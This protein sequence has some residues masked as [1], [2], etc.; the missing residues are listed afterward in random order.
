MNDL[1]QLSTLAIYAAMACYAI[2]LVGFSVDLSGLTD[3]GPSGRRRRA[4]GIAMATTNAGIA[5]HVAGVVLRGLAAGRVPWANMYEFTLVFS[6]VA[7]L[8]FVVMQRRRDVR[9][10]G[11]FLMLITLAGLGVGMSVL[12]VDAVG[13]EPI[14]DS[15]WLVIHVSIAT[16]AVGVFAVAAVISVVQLIKDHQEVAARVAA[17]VREQETVGAATV[18]SDASADGGVETLAP[19]A[20]SVA[21]DS[22]RPGFWSRWAALLPGSVVLERWAY[23]LNAVGFLLWTFTLIA[24]A[25]WA[26]HAWGRPWGWDAK[27]TWTFVIWVAYAAYLHA[28]ATRG[29]D[30]R[31]AAYFCLTGFALVLGNYFI[32]NLL[33]NTRHGYAFG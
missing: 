33:L 13:V 22:P 11:A 5:L 12:Y 1:G 23:R 27:E 26:E 30:G 31:K 6:M 25:I 19:A 3:R 24:G 10:L 16:I 18:A 9:F 4:A 7:V 2:A 8:I 17:E 32:V 20:D 21:P 28:R 29:W 14:L 15:Y